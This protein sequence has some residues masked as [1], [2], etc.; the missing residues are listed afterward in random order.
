MLPGTSEPKFAHNTYLQMWAELGIV[1]LMLF[2]AIVI[3]LVACTAS[4]AR[5]FH[6]SGDGRMEALAR[7]LF[8]AQ[9]GILGMAFFESIALTHQ[10]WLLLATGP[11]LLALARESEG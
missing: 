5:A 10:P 8:A 3:G 7:S 11:P 2:L 9:V 4:A 6:R 1:G